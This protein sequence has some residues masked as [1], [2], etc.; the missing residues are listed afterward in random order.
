MRAI[1]NFHCEHT[2]LEH[3]VCDISSDPSTTI[4]GKADAFFH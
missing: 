4:F 3:R 2:S 1:P